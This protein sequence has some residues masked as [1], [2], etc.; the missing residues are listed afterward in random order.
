MDNDT[1]KKYFLLDVR[2]LEQYS[3]IRKLRV[4]YAVTA[5]FYHDIN[6]SPPSYKYMQNCARKNTIEL[7]IKLI[8]SSQFIWTGSL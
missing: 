8:R 7:I 2:H 1:L 5:M 6:S 4:Y 3:L